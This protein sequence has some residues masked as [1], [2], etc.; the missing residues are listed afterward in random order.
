MSPMRLHRVN[1]NILFIGDIRMFDETPYSISNHIFP[2]SLASSE[3]RIGWLEGKA[4]YCDE[5]RDD[6]IFSLAHP[7]TVSSI[8]RS[9][10][11]L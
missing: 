8:N 6:A 1:E 5:V 9:P 11:T 7:G 4:L 10:W 3:T 2:E